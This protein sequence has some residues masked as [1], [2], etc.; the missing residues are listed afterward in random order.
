MN[1]SVAWR[2]V[3]MQALKSK[4][5][6]RVTATLWRKVEVQWPHSEV[7]FGVWHKGGNWKKII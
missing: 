1:Y 6:T 7:D 4:Q 5:E 2:E 3:G